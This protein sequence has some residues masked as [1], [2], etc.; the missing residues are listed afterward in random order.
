MPVLVPPSLEGALRFRAAGGVDDSELA[1]PDK[2]SGT[3]S[4]ARDPRSSV[5]RG[6]LPRRHSALARGLQ[7]VRPDQWIVHSPETWCSSDVTEKGGRPFYAEF[8]WTFDLI[9]DRP[10]RKERCVSTWH[11]NPTSGRQARS[12]LSQIDIKA[13][14]T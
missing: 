11:P 9:I 1:D 6:D 4:G 8:E 13:S 5:S 14:D 2:P 7:T 12:I 10:V 3:T